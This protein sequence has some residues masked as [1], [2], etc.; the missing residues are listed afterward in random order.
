MEKNQ[1]IFLQNKKYGNLIRENKTS[2]KLKMTFILKKNSYGLFLKAFESFLQKKNYFPYEMTLDNFQIKIFSGKNKII[3]IT[4]IFQI[5]QN[6]MGFL[7]YLRKYYKHGKL[8]K[9][10]DCLMFLVKLLQF[11]IFFGYQ[12]NKQNS[13]DSLSWDNILVKIKKSY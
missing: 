1:E 4:F 6:T 5:E 8:V 11:G 3:E 13:E 7:D 9:S 12:L 2:T 10:I